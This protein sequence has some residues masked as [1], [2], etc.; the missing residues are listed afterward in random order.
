MSRIANTAT[1]QRHDAQAAKEQQG[2][3]GFSAGGQILDQQPKD[4]PENRQGAEK[5]EQPSQHRQYA[6]SDLLA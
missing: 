5:D 1:V 3:A 2:P 4:H 6:V